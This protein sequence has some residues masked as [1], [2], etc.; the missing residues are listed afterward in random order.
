MA[1][2]E[3]RCNDVVL[4]SGQVTGRGKK[5]G[6]VRNVVTV[7]SI[8]NNECGDGQLKKGNG[9]NSNRD[10]NKIDQETDERERDKSVS[11]PRY[12]I[13]RQRRPDTRSFLDLDPQTALLYQ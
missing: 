6:R 5:Q 2:V 9:S 13:N 10:W 11:E 7:I 8:L 1:D 4:S 12:C 3:L